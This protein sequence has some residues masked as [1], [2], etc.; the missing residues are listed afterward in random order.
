MAESSCVRTRNRMREMAAIEKNRISRSTHTLACV[1]QKKVQG[2]I[3]SSCIFFSFGFYSSCAPLAPRG[4]R[5]R[6]RIAA[7]WVPYPSALIT[8]RRNHNTSFP[9]RRG[10]WGWEPSGPRR[11]DTPFHAFVY[12]SFHAEFS[13]LG[14]CRKL[15]LPG[16]RARVY[17]FIMARR[18]RFTSRLCR[19]RV[20]Y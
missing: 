7:G 3:S 17:I 8:L 18:G 15:Q 12:I 4:A 2:G 11:C 1:L 9:R 16:R 13:F 10:I 14:S 20:M 6:T 19:P 5:W